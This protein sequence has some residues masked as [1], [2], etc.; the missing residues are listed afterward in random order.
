LNILGSDPELFVVTGVF[1]NGT[2]VFLFSGVGIEIGAGSN[3]YL[4]TATVLIKGFPII[5]RGVSTALI[6]APGAHVGV[7]AASKGGAAN[8]AFLELLCQKATIQTGAGLDLGGTLGGSSR[9]SAAPSQDGVL[10]GILPAAGS[11]V[12]VDFTAPH[13]AG[14]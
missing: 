11:K 4:V 2:V 3:L 8:G 7:V 5:A 1:R 12:G 9:G 13:L 6:S 14:R 10:D